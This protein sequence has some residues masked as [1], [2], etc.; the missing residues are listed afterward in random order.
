M[1]IFSNLYQ[2]KGTATCNSWQVQLLY[3]ISQLTVSAITVQER[4]LVLI[5]SSSEELSPVNLFI[6]AWAVRL[7]ALLKS[8]AMD[9]ET[10]PGPCTQ[11]GNSDSSSKLLILSK[12]FP[13]LCSLGLNLNSPFKDDNRDTRQQLLDLRSH[14]S[15]CREILPC[16]WVNWQKQDQ[17]LYQQYME[18]EN[19]KIFTLNIYYENIQKLSWTCFNPHNLTYINCVKFSSVILHWKHLIYV[20]LSSCTWPSTWIYRPTYQHQIELLLQPKIKQCTTHKQS[21]NFKS[22]W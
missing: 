1:R 19:F 17:S 5:I 18:E 11:P 2:R 21:R 13:L 6:V 9:V 4:N 8:I 7:S 10:Q 15:L 12:R 22:P 14:K 16:L 20:H 3:P